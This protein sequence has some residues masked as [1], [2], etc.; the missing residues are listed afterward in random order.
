M[1]NPRRRRLPTTLIAASLG[2]LLAVE[3][4]GIALARS[5]PVVVVEPAVAPA[6]V[7]IA[8]DAPVGLG[9]ALGRAIGSAST[10]TTG[11]IVDGLRSASVLTTFF[12]P[13]AE[14]TKGHVKAAK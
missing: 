10:V 5:N 14:P 6:A 13:A 12:A 11:P 9:S 2:V 1:R 7:A 4:T 3:V 8:D